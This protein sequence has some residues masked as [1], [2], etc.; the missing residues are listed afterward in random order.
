MSLARSL[1]LLAIF[2]LRSIGAHAADPVSPLRALLVTGGCCHDY[3]GQKLVLT[4]GIRARANVTWT[5]VHEG[6]K[7]TDHR[8]SIFEQAD[9]AKNYDVVVH[10]EC[11]ATVSDEAF[12]ERVAAAHRGGTAAV[13]IHCAMHTFRDCKTDTWR[14]LLGVT[15]RRH[16]RQHPLAVKNLRPEHPVMKGFPPVLQ[17][18]DEELYMIEKLWPHT[19]S[20]AQA[21]GVDTKQD[22]TVIW[23]NTYG[24]GRV[25]GTTLMHHTANMRQEVYLD[26]VS[27]GLLW[28]C[29]KLDAEGQPV[30][31]YG[32]R[33]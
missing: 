26:L 28:A 14:E 18:T 24:K 8:V 7:S 15:T 21:Y 16:E 23:T 19:T 30:A 9:W 3:D 11:F 10:N 4:E 33:K 27:R 25:F 17:T 1:A 22:H 5:I 6:G 29:D 12:V 2:L 13:V 31:G 20:L 32:A